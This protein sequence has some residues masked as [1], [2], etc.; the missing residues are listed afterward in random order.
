MLKVYFGKLHRDDDKGIV[1]S[2]YEAAAIQLHGIH[3]N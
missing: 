1:S 3:Y 2:K